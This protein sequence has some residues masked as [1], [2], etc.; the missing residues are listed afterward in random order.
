VK[1]HLKA[2]LWLVVI[3]VGGLFIANAA[4][5]IS[6]S[7]MI[8]ALHT[9]HAPEITEV[10]EPAKAT[11][12]EPAAIFDQYLKLAQQGDPGAQYNLAMLYYSGKEVPQDYIMAADWYIKSAKNGNGKAFYQLGQMSYMGQGVPQSH[13]RAAYRYRQAAALGNFAA[14]SRLQMMYAQGLSVPQKNEMAMLSQPDLPIQDDAGGTKVSS[15]LEVA[16]KNNDGKIKP[17]DKS[18]LVTSSMPLPNTLS[19]G[20]DG[21]SLGDEMECMLEPHLVSNIG[22]PVEGVL[23]RVYV[24]RGDYVSK[25]QILA[26]LHADVEKATVEWRKAQEAFGLRQVKRNEELFKKELIST[27]EKDEMET[28]T[29]IAG[30]EL[31]EKQQILNQRTIRSPLNGVVVERS[32]VPGEHVAQE[33]ILKIAQINPLNVEMVMPVEMFGKIK[34][35]MVANVRLSPLLNGTYHAKVIV[36]DKVIDAGSGTFGVR[37]E[38]RNPGNKIP[39]GIKCRLSF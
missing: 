10:K 26:Q 11:S 2:L 20:N 30:L 39:S 34:L 3:S 18:P 29:R 24:D 12:I 16:I 14:K 6:L 32:L 36:I 31:K 17:V 37:L 21:K 1:R 15:N 33:K 22:S 27:N 4:N 19:R 9:A 23:S 28:Q 8:N 35:G 5:L 7:Q 38:L 25:G 13:K